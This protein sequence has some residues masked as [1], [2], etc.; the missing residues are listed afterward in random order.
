MKK[1][2]LFLLAAMLTPMAVS[3]ASY[4]IDEN[5]EENL[6]GINKIVFELKS[7]NC[8]ICISTGNQSYSLTGG[9]KSENLALSLEGDLKSNNKKAVPSLITE[10]TGDV[11]HVRLYKDRNLF[12]GLVQGGSIHFS[13]VLPKYFDGEIEVLTSSGDT[14]ITDLNAKIIKMDSSSGDTDAVRLKADEIEITASSGDLTVSHITAANSMSLKASS[15][16]ISLAE[17]VS[18]EAEI[19]A[20]SGRIAIGRLTSSDYLIIHASSGRI[21]AENLESG[22]VSIDSNSGKIT[23]EELTAEEASVDASS[24]DIT[25]SKMTAVK[26]DIVSSSGDTT[27]GVIALNGDINIKCS[28]GDVNLEL[29]AGTAF[30]ADL[31]ASSGKIRSG[32]RLLS[33]V[34]GDRKNEI[35]GD[36]NGGG[37]S[38]RVKASSGN[39]TIEEK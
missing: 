14:A 26:A 24:G 2:L 23:I 1:I 12:F 33:E 22:S 25:I 20:S 39:I 30:T 6:S 21:S 36:A 5:K 38:I 35:K 32:F 34:S 7:P 27:I 15:G 17:G 16:D 4:N 29:P 10:K 31:S 28:S 18:G 9:G 8:A 3:A 13:A 11:L 37:H 19:K